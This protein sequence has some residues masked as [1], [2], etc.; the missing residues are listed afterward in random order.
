MFAYIKGIVEKKTTTANGAYLL[1]LESHGFGLEMHIS[2]QTFIHLPERGEEMQ[3]YSVFVIKE[4][5]CMLFGFAQEEEK[6][7][8]YCLLQSRVLGPN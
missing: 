6:N 5:E 8:F 2:Q 4:S 1:V 7:S 3:I